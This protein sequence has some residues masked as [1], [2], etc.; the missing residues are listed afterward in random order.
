MRQWYGVSTTKPQ[1]L[2]EVRDKIHHAIS[3]IPLAKIQTV[4]RSVL[5]NCWEFTVA[6]G[7]YFEHV[8]A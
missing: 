1:T 5:R 4:C 8:W 3:D 6:E 2:E 7:G